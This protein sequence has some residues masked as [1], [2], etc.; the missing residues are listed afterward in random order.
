MSHRLLSESI[1]LSHLS[2]VPFQ[3]PENHEDIF[4]DP[5]IGDMRQHK[6]CELAGVDEAGCDW[7]AYFNVTSGRVAFWSLKKTHADRRVGHFLA[8]WREIPPAKTRQLIADAISGSREVEEF[9]SATLPDW[10]WRCS[11]KNDSND[12]A[13]LTSA[14][15]KALLLDTK[16]ATLHVSLA[17]MSITATSGFA[18]L[19]ISFWYGALQFAF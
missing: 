4:R 19:C 5:A 15:R 17:T 8:D 12:K 7:V 18:Y 13:A 10:F 14:Y 16:D 2:L 3:T 11:T 9:L 1:V 6:L